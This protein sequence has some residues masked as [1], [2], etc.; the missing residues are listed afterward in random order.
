MTFKENTLNA[1]SDFTKLSMMFIFIFVLSR[2]HEI[3][4]FGSEH[5][6]NGSEMMIQ[7]GGILFDLIISVRILLFLLI[8]FMPLYYIHRNIALIVYYILSSIIVILNLSLISY[9]KLSIIPLGND[10]FGYSLDE[11]KHTVNASGGSGFMTYSLI[12]LLFGLFLFLSILIIRISISKRTTMIMVSM[13]LFINLFA[14]QISPDASYYGNDFKYYLAVNKT[15]YF[16]TDVLNNTREY[17]D[18]KSIKKFNVGTDFEYI[19]KEYPLLHKENTPDVLS[20]YFNK[21]DNP[22]NLVFIIVESL[23]RA[24]CGPNSYLGS[25]TPFVDSLIGKSLYWEN[26]LSTGGRTFAALPSIFGSLPFGN[27]GFL[28]LD[29]KMP[30]HQSLLK[31]LKKDGYTTSFY[32]GGDSHF[33]LM[34]NFL[35]KQNIDNIYDNANFGNEYSKLPAN[36]EGFAWGYG[37]KEIFRKNLEVLKNNNH[38]P[39]VDIF[40]TLAMHSP[41]LIPNQDNYNKKFEK[42]MVEIGLKVEAKAERR[43]YHQNFECILYFDDALRYFVHEYSKRDDYKNTIF[44][45]T[46]DHRMPEIPISTQIDRFHVPLIVFSPMLKKS[47]MFSSVSTQFDV[48]PTIL[49]FLHKS[50]GTKIPYYTAWIGHGLDVSA[51]HNKKCSYPL[52]RNKNE[53]VDYIDGSYFLSSNK[54]Y[55]LLDNMYIEK[56][57]SDASLEAI[58]LKFNNFRAINDY[59]CRNNKLIPDSLNSVSDTKLVEKADLSN[60]KTIENKSDLSKQS[61]PRPVLSKDRD[62]QL[63]WLKANDIY[64]IYDKTI[65]IK[66]NRKINIG[67]FIVTGSFRNLSNATKFSEKLKGKGIKSEIEFNPKQ[68]IYHVYTYKSHDLFTAVKKLYESWKDKRYNERVFLYSF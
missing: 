55:S 9:F 58:K 8:I 17:S 25:F 51:G 26:F 52:M 53:M 21:T 5:N 49:S 41:F 28:E 67:Y 68:K 29:D 11:I 3:I 22:P 61:D 59:V 7:L 36:N 56:A 44:I 32:Y 57:K 2:F 20:Q 37:D 43:S 10:L 33:D 1:A 46:G 30:A 27:K 60:V 45:I 62:Q 39:R 12:I 13:I 18:I 6:F 42:R 4:M 31:V 24:Y 35:R 66:N 16:V 47:K 48:T 23:G 34:D 65:K 40:L 54:L 14:G 50:Y 63:E 15:G 38:K 64:H 19:S